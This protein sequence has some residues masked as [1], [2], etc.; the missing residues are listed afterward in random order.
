MKKRPRTK[1]STTETMEPLREID[2]CGRQP[3][4]AGATAA[5]SVTT[6]P[7]PG[8]VARAE[9]TEA[10]SR[11][12]VSAARRDQARFFELNDL[13]RDRRDELR[14]GESRTPA[15]RRVQPEAA[16]NVRVGHAGKGAPA[17]AQRQRV[18][19]A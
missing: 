7:C 1:L 8:R 13:A 11:C 14:P 6:L 17:L 2:P 4:T 10:D 12:G 18:P 15:V 16:G 9:E 19:P 3:P 5:S